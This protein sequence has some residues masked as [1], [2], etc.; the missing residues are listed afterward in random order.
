MG[1]KNFTYE[2]N[3]SSHVIMKEGLND[4]VRDMSLFKEQAGRG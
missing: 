2:P 4:L 3:T 1:A